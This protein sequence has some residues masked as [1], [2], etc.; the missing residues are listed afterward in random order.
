M[1]PLPSSHHIHVTLIPVCILL[2]LMLLLPLILLLQNAVDGASGGCG[3]AANF[4]NVV[5]L[6]NGVV[7]F[8]TGSN[9]HITI[10]KVFVLL[11]LR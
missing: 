1:H 6:L 5:M 9:S 10:T 4:S 7:D 8:S 11:L 2:L 3:P